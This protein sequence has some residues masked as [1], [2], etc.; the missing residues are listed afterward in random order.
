MSDP[1]SSM[2]EEETDF[3][4]FQK[5]C[6][7]CHRWCRLEDNKPYCIQCERKCYRVC[8]KCHRPF[9]E[10]KYFE[11]D[12]KR[13]NACHKKYLVEREKRIARKKTAMNTKGA[14]NHKTAEENSTA[15][16]M[17]KRGS[18][19][20][21]NQHPADEKVNPKKRAKDVMS[22]SSD[23]EK[24]EKIL[25]MGPSRGK[26]ATK[27]RRV[28]TK[29]YDLATA[30]EEDDDDD[31]D[32]DDNE[33]ESVT[34][35]AGRSTCTLRDPVPS[36]MRRIVKLGL[37]G[38]EPRRYTFNVPLKI[39]CYF[40]EPTACKEKSSATDENPSCDPLIT[41]KDTR[42]ITGEDTRKVELKKD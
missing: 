38:D 1:Q 39:V 42:K 37:N 25:M 26:Q 8:L 20:K 33:D 23:G 2:F 41:S 7:W 40:G 27:K 22:D 34:V 29:E 31:D 18:K 21:Q 3:E 5:R 24:E 14:D 19:K 4:D 30:D 6:N 11:D 17:V 35:T 10:A 28:I 13:C 15:N 16:M 32:D 36:T 12:E 9:P